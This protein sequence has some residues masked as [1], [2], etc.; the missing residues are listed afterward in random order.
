VTPRQQRLFPLFFL[1]TFATYLGRFGFGLV[2]AL[3]L[4]RWAARQRSDEEIDALVEM[5]EGC[6]SPGSVG[7]WS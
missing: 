6:T 5:L 2:D 1:H 4:A 3:A 7:T